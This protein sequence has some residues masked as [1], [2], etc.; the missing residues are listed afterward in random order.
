MTRF[1]FLI[2][3]AVFASMF[4]PAPAAAQNY[5]TLPSYRTSL[6]SYH[7]TRPSYRAPAPS[8]LPTMKGIL[9]QYNLG[10][11]RQP[12]PQVDVNQFLQSLRPSETAFRDH[13]R[14]DKIIQRNSITISACHTYSR[15]CL[16]R[17]LSIE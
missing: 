4:N 14:G 17:L 5:T 15:E 16:N 12:R 6:P 11:Q 2:V 13:V 3:L 1:S 9:K 7:I 10:P 8:H